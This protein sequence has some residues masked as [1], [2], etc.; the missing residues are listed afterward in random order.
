MSSLLLHC[1][2]NVETN[3]TFSRLGNDLACVYV[4][5]F[6]PRAKFARVGGRRVTDAGAIDATRV[7]S[8]LYRDKR[9]QC[10]VCLSVRRWRAGPF[11]SARGKCG[12]VPR[13]RF[14]VMRRGERVS[15]VFFW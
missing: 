9:L 3:E 2:N 10:C 8:F 1:N 15:S 4:R 14:G 5:A 7:D 13:D 12:T 6:F 11:I